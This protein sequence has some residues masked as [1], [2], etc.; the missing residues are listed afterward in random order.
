MMSGPG[1]ACQ[2]DALTTASFE[3]H[4][5]QLTISAR[6]HSPTMMIGLTSSEKTTLNTL[7]ERAIADDCHLASPLI[8]IIFAE[9]D[10]SAHV[11]RDGHRRR[12]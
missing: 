4:R 5:L 7:V 11:S 9:L 3:T 12:L 2:G 6:H 10:R 1:S 8:P